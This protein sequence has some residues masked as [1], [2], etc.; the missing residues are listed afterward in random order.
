MK[1]II[2]SNQEQGQRLDK[3]LKKY[4]ANAGGS[5]LYKMLRKKN[6]V[7]NQKKADGH[8]L[9]Q[10][11]DVICVYFSEETFEKMRGLEVL[12]QQEDELSKVG[13][14]QLQVIYEDADILVV[15]KPSGVL[16]QKAQPTDISM[17]EMILSYLI[18]QGTWN[19][20]TS[21][22]FKPSVANRLDRN[23][24][25]L[26]LA[27]KTLPGQQLLSKLLQDRTLCKMYH[28]IVQG[29]IKKKQRIQGYLTKDEKQN[30]VMIYDHPISGGSYIETEYEP[31]IQ[32]RNLT[33]LQVHLITGKS[34]QIRAHL[35]SIG[36]PIIGDYKYGSASINEP[37]RRKYQ[38]K[39]QLLHSYSME[40]PDGRRFVAPDPE[41]FDIIVK[42]DIHKE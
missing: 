12:V 32:G 20:N 9:L 22:G 39:N 26:L 14:E 18:E 25:G 28:C 19:A 34:H 10:T 42:E 1:E 2:I 40:F 5:F 3:F 33:Y 21:N 23:T 15:N 7:L 31:L 16:S 36:H 37:Y 4:F 29:N 8:E 30:K 17:N 35:S 11:S 6:I 41:I 27:G 13:H 38:V 24:S